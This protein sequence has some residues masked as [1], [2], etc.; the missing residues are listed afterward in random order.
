MHNF[1]AKEL[2]KTVVNNVLDN[3]YTLHFRWWSF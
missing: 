3:L 2:D 1:Y